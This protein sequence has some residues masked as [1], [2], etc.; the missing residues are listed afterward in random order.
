MKDP[1]KIWKPWPGSQNP[2]SSE[3]WQRIYKSEACTSKCISPCLCERWDSGQMGRES[4]CS[5]PA[6]LLP[7]ADTGHVWPGLRM[8]QEKTEALDYYMKFSSLY[9]FDFL[10][11]MCNQTIHVYGQNPLSWPYFGSTASDIGNGSYPLL[12]IDTNGP[13]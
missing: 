11:T 1:V 8:S 6:G 9:R 7:C 5:A 13:Q 10:K 12:S 2:R 4:H 3:T